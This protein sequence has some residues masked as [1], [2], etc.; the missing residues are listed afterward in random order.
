LGGLLSKVGGLLGKVGSALGLASPESETDQEETRALE[1]C[2]NRWNDLKN[3]Y[4]VYHQSIWEA[5]LFYANQTWIDWD[6]ARKVWQPQQPNDEWVPKPRINRFS[7]TVDAVCS[8]FYK[9]PTVDPVPVPDDS[10]LSMMVSEVAE[11]LIDHFVVENGFKSQ[12]KSLADK[13]GVAAQLFVLAGGCFSII[14]KEEVLIGN[15]PKTET[16]EGQGWQCQG[17]DTY[18]AG[19]APEA[20]EAPPMDQTSDPERGTAP[21]KNCAQCGQPMQHIPNAKIPGQPVM[22]ENGEPQTEDM[23]QWNIRCDIGNPLY[24]LPRPGASSVDDSPYFLWAE[25]MPLDTIY[26]RYDGFEASAD[27]IWPDGYSITYEH[28]LN[29]WYTGYSSST[30]QTKDSCMVLQCYVAPQKVKEFPD[31]MYIVQINDECA[32]Y[33]AW[34][35]PEHPLTLCCY[36]TLPTIFFPRSISFD[37]TQIQRELNAYESLI[38]LHGMTSSTDPIVIDANTMVSEVTGRADKV[39]KWR[40]ISPNSKEPHRLASGHLDDGIY[41][42]RDNLHAE[43]QNISMAVNAFRGE[44]E[45]AIVAASAI[46][47]LRG[48]A[49]QMFSKPQENWA[50]FWKETCRKA[51]KF[52]QKYYTFAQI[53]QILGPD[54]IPHVREF[55]RAD[56]DKALEFIAS[57]GSAPRTRD[58]RKQELMTM[59]DK[60]ALDISNP[61][62]RENIY[63]L[64]GETGMME[65]FNLDATRAR[66]ENMAFKEG[67]QASVIK[68]MVGIEDLAT[69]LS[70]HKSKVKR[71]EFD[72][73]PQPAKQQLMQHIDDTNKALQQQQMEQLKQQAMV[74]EKMAPAGKKVSQIQGEEGQR[75]SQA[76]GAQA[77]RPGQPPKGGPQPA[78]KGPVQ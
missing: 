55:M 74:A 77:K 60:G 35:F 29:F 27:S 58:E 4:V 5:L 49:E 53:V 50:N 62:V 18:E 20:P 19:P 46:S 51:V 47:Q 2:T 28:A 72:S 31:G 37:L 41:K 56:L 12:Y 24:A 57:K 52:Y 3:A 30:I 33:E 43:F 54:K 45:G 75:A 64:F 23:H 69:H 9:I 36:L 21:T 39:I 70:I 66:L 34:D 8:N 10:C 11:K 22:G 40:S 6:D 44:Q 1:Y 13:A 78:A 38:K 48:Q 16:V 67:G 26:F 65:E 71:L 76:A 63:E 14:R 15:R 59:W 25:R 61:D 42:Q 73:W 17:C 32:H 7:P 68:P